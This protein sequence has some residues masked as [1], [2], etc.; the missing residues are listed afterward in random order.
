LRGRSLLRLRALALE[1]APLLPQPRTGVLARFVL[2]AVRERR[3]RALGVAT[4]LA[5]APLLLLDPPRARGR[6]PLL[7]RRRLVAALTA[8]LGE[9]LRA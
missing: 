7:A 6:L 9:A 5:C 4:E 1:R 3:A 2:A 8:C